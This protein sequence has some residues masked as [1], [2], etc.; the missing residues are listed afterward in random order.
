M[1]KALQQAKTQL[2]VDI[3]QQVARV[4]NHG[5]F[6]RSKG[7]V[8]L[9][10]YLF[11]KLSLYGGQPASQRELATVLG[12]PVDF[13]PVSNPLVRMHMS[14]LRR[15]LKRYA[16]GPG[17]NDPIRLEIPRSRYQLIAATNSERSGRLERAY[18]VLQNCDVQ[19][20]VILVCE[21]SCEAECLDGLASEMAFRLV[22]MLAENTQVAAIGPA[23]RVRLDAEGLEIQSFAERC[24]ARLALVGEVRPGQ[25]GLTLVVRVFDVQLGQVCWTD[26][27]DEP[28][29]RFDSPYKDVASLLAARVVDKLRRFDPPPVPS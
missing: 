24:Q 27:L 13:D 16:D 15:M 26:W 25:R 20:P 3:E 11:Q 22:A 12:L 10:G 8:R 29:D 1:Q 18:P 17:H 28:I 2:L 14:K 9:L 4:L 5:S 19:R 6:S 21:F 23:L 7:P